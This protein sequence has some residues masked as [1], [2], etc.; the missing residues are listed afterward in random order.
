[1]TDFFYIQVPADVRVLLLTGSSLNKN[2]LDQV[3]KCTNLLKLDLSNCNISQIP[4]L[5]KLTNLR[6][7]Y[8]H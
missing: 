3:Y 2:Q 5:K 6:I 1:M 7:L 8:L 4:N